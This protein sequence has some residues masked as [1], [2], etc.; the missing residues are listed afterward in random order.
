[1]TD[2]ITKANA[3]L[4]ATLRA[5]YPNVDLLEHITALSIKAI[6]RDAI[7]RS[8]LYYFEAFSK[9]HQ[10]SI[11]RQNH[12]AND[13]DETRRYAEDAKR[14]AAYAHEHAH[15]LK[16][17]DV[18]VVCSCSYCEISGELLNESPER[19][20]RERNVCAKVSE[21]TNGH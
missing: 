11:K 9:E 14:F 12:P 1:M 13:R 8:S 5:M 17:A 3:I 16:L 21:G 10:N 6:Q 20:V 2:D 19:M 4:G 18:Q 7:V 15:V